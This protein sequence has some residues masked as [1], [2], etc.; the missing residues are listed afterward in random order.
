MENQSELIKVDDNIKRIREQIAE[1][2]LRSGRKSEDVRFMAVTKLQEN[3]LVNRAIADGIDLIGE[4]YVKEFLDKKDFLN[5]D[6][7]EKH[8]IGHLQTNKVRKIITEVDMIE[9]VDSMEVAEEIER[10]CEKHGV[11]MN[12]LIEV[13]IGGEQSKTGF[14]ISEVEEKAAQISELGRVKIQGL[15]TIPPATDDKRELRRLFEEMRKLFVDIQDKKQ[16]N[17]NMNILSMGMSHDYIEAVECG[18][19]EVRIGSAVFGARDYS[20]KH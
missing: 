14:D 5:L 13:N 15:M 3:Y 10:Q 12:V 2:A 1:A 20:K 6:G 8:L 11:D 4:N 17:I 19:T 18:S 16:D 7:V 9:S